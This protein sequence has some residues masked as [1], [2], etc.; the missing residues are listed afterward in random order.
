MGEGR[1]RFIAQRLDGLVDE[2]RPGRPA[3]ISL[4]QVEQVIIDT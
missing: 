2:P 3:T 4:D 1:S